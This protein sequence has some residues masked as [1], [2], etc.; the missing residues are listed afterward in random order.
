MAFPA[1]KY[2][3]LNMIPK[4]NG[5]VEL[6]LKFLQISEN[7]VNK[8]YNARDIN[9]FQNDFLMSCIIFKIKGCF[10]FHLQMYCHLQVYK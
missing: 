9:A 10:A 8:F 6:L 2:E 5:N 4:F 7:L 3:H 1:L